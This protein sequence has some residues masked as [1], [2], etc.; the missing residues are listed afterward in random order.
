MNDTIALPQIVPLRREAIAELI[1]LAR[2]TW[3][4]HYPSIISTEQIEYMLARGYLPEG[5]GAQ[6]DGGGVWWDT[7]VDAGRMVAFSC[8]EPSTQR[9]ELKIDKLYV[10]YDLR[11]H[12]HGGAL[13]R[14]AEKRARDLG[15][16]RL[17]LQ[18]NRHNAESIEAYRRCGFE[19]ER[20]LVVDIGGGFFM[21]DYVMAKNLGLAS[22]EGVPP[23]GTKG[24]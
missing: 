10:R 11:G 19:V 4:R 17:F 5:I 7:L 9:S 8:C 20:T 3:H 6:L 14:H 21:D 22:P 15:F 1:A 16:V 23:G 24:G 18:V 13:L 2:D 12:G